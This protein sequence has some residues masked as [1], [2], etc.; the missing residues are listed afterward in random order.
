MSNLVISMSMK[1]NTNII[2]DKYF[3]VNNVKS[4]EEKLKNKNM[5]KNWKDK[6]FKKDNVIYNLFKNKI[7]K[8]LKIVC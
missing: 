5:K 3:K 4:L 7:L 6:F 8:N 2:T 1:I